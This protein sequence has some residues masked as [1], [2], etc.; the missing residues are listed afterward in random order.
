M[1]SDQ[2]ITPLLSVVVPSFNCGRFIRR[3]IESVVRQHVNSADYE[4]VIVDNLSTDATVDVLEQYWSPAVRIIREQDKGQ[5]DALN[6][7]FGAARGEWLCW[8]NAD[9]EFVPGA[10]P[11]VIEAL[12]AAGDAN[13]MSGGMIWMDVEGTVIRC[14]PNMRVGPLL[15]LLG[16]ANV[17]GP[18]SFFRR[19]LLSRAGGFATDFH[20]CMDTDMWYRFQRL[21]ER[22]RPIGGYVWGFRI[23]EASKTSHVVLTSTRSPK[24][25]AELDRMKRDYLPPSA[26]RW[27]V[28]APWAWRV[29]ALLTGR[30]LQAFRDT[31]RYRGRPLA[32]VEDTA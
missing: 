22:C 26:R 11:R 12:R 17:G 24:M 7:G 21:G 32:A 19:S 23:H 15:Q 13:W 3:A 8:L 6:K 9:D 10:L 27:S 2:A 31:Q 25:T 28:L 14:A 29:C 1:A 16:V 18:S 20:F 30:D 5:S 4:L